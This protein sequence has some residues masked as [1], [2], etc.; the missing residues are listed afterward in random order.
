MQTV[1]AVDYIVGQITF[2]IHETSVKWQVDAAR[3]P[4]KNEGYAIWM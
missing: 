3:N 4:D 1:T 2:P